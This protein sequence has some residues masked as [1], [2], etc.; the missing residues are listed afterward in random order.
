[1]TMTVTGTFW[2]SHDPPSTVPVTTKPCTPLR[3]GEAVIEFSIVYTATT[4]FL[5]NRTDYTPPFATIDVPTYCSS[6]DTLG[7]PMPTEE[8]QTSSKKTGGL[9][10]STI[11]TTDGDR[12]YTIP[13]SPYLT[14][15]SPPPAAPP[16]PASSRST[17]TFVTTDK[18]PSSTF[19]ND[20]IPG[21]SQTWD[22]VN[23][24]G[25][26]GGVHKTAANN[27]GGGGP[28]QPQP[29]YTV[30]AGPDTVVIN[31]S[32]FTNLQPGKT[33]TVVVGDGTFT[34]SPTA[35]VGEGS[36]IQKPQPGGDN[37]GAA[38]PTTKLLDGV[39]VVVSGTNAVVGGTTVAIPTDGVATIIDGKSVSVGPGALIVGDKTLTLVN[40]P[41]RTDV[42]VA[43]GE[44]LTAIGPSVVVI[45]ST[46]LTYGPGIAG[47]TEVVDDDTI[48][49]GPSGVVVHG[50]TLGGPDAS[51][52]D[53]TYEIVGG[54]TITELGQ[55]LVVIDGKTY[56]VGPDAD[57]TTMVVGGQTITIGPDGVT[58]ATMTM[59]YP[60]G[61]VVTT[62]LPS[63][64]WGNDMP[65]ETGGQVNV[66]GGSPD[67]GDG[68]EDAG[69]LLRPSLGWGTTG[70]CIA[71]G[72]WV[73]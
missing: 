47:T 64:T 13:G 7:L 9:Q 3:D 10:V 17:T 33:Q 31:D 1:M 37:G 72:V 62:I 8:P 44:M 67:D 50:S 36:S 68:D 70:L 55:S 35:V 46:T 58:V 20:P 56:T 71:I 30:T 6:S 48:S 19:P 26:G 18:N 29:T 60:F 22:N 14:S 41:A 54:A 51:T 34:I 11:I 45:H 65:V 28:K 52:T 25:G 12:T 23:G 15:D 40:A 4:T 24:G 63:G 66:N 43:G 39:S 5:G 21:Y 2:G 32:T 27:G 42:V 69:A 73:L 38:S 49:I 59:T 61:S 53:T 57:K 16:P